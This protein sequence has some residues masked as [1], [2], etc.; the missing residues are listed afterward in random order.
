MKSIMYIDIAY[1]VCSTRIKQGFDL[2]YRACNGVGHL[3]C[4]FSIHIAFIRP[5]R[6]FFVHGCGELMGEKILEVN[7]REKEVIERRLEQARA[8][9][10]YTE[11]ELN[12]L[13]PVFLTENIFRR[14]NVEC[15]KKH[16][17]G[18]KIFE[19]YDKVSKD[20]GFAGAAY[21]DSDVDVYSLVKE[22]VGTGLVVFS[23]TGRVKEEIV[24][25]ERNIGYAGCDKLMRTNVLS[26]RYSKKG[27]HATPVH[28]LKYQDTIEFLKKRSNGLL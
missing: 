2:F 8:R 3:Q 11:Y 20:K 17:V 23:M 21:F 6:S 5:V 1:F 14:I 16:I 10:L 26:I 7:S 27:I 24:C 15:Q 28:P 22:L 13:W 25:I 18:T 12:V 9:E 19:N 4:S